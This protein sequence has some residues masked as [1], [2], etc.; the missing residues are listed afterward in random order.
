MLSEELKLR[1][2]VC[3]RSVIESYGG[4][5]NMLRVRTPASFVQKMIDQGQ[6]PERMEIAAELAANRAEAEQI[7]AGVLGLC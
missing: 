1:I 6:T 3:T 4:V 5:D 2:A 7:V